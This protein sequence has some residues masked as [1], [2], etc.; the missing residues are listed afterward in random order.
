MKPLA[1]I[2]ALATACFAASAQQPNP[3]AQPVP[4]TQDQPAQTQPA[5]QPNGSLSTVL[6]EAAQP[7]VLP[8]TA[9]NSIATVALEGVS[10]SGSLSVEN[11]LA[12]IGNNG[13]ITAGDH[14]ARVS[15]T[16]GGRLN[17]CAS[18]KIH[19]STDNTISGGGLMIALDR[20]AL[21]ARYLPGPY[22]DVILTPDLRIL[23]SG[24]GQTDLSLRVS[25]QGDTCIDNHGDHAPYV[26]ASSLFEGGAYRVQPNQRV[27]FNRGSLQ[28][29]VDNETESCGCPPPE[30]V[31]TPTTIVGVGAPGATLRSET[32]STPPPSPDQTS[33]AAQNPFP[34]AE[35]EGLKPPP[36]PTTPVVPAGQV[37]TQITVPLIYNGETA[38]NAG[39]PTSSL[40]DA[41]CQDPLFPGVVCDSS[42]AANRPA[43]QSGQA[44]QTAAG[45]PAEENATPR[46]KRSGFVRF[47]RKVFGG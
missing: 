40:S 46:K 36:S 8:P 16:R 10:L 30:P 18:T 35:S 5:P 6:N 28:Q 44:S 33:T 24:P 38:E 32:Q 42:A 45:Q 37:H 23:I 22:S 9:P 47:L 41:A 19:L 11:G 15:L 25:N 20:G 39:M 34:T 31:P 29:V 1:T 12:F 43:P 3:P 4:A 14:T 26:V 17:V 7:L 21:E 2:L 27:L 13:A